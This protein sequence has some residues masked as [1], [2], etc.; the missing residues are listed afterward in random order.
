MGA[1]IHLKVEV[2]TE[3]GWIDVPAPDHFDDGSYWGRQWYSGRNYA[4][5]SV[6][7]NVRNFREPTIVPIA[8]PRGLPDGLPRRGDEWDFGDHSFSWVTLAELMAY[9]P[10]PDFGGELKGLIPELQKLGDPENVR[11]VFGFDS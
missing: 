5:F 8:E 3:S 11:L 6:L 9:G 1:D 7:A 10:W 4:D 2:L